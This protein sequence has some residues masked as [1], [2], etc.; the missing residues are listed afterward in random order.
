MMTEKDMVNDALNNINSAL[1]SYA[2]A[3]SQTENKELR[4]ALIQMRNQAETSQYDLYMIA[5]NK[6]Y[7]VPAQQASQDEINQVKAELSSCSNA[8]TSTRDT[9]LDR[10][11]K[12]SYISSQTNGILN[13]MDE[14]IKHALR[15]PAR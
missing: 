9:V 5:K 14:Q 15:T 10:S 4:N 8:E 11:V 2:S 12:S 13:H 6:S 7:Y 3:I 1:T